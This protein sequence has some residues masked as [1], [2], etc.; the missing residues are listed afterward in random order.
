MNATTSTAPA[1]AGTAAA[2]G[3]AGSSQPALVVQ[4]LVSGYT[5]EVDI[6]RGVGLEV[7]RGEI[8][9]VLGPNGAGKSTLIKTIAGLVPVRSGQVML[10]GQ[11]LVGIAAHRMVSRGLA[12]VP[13]TN[14]IFSRMSIEEN[15][16]MGACARHD[17]AGID[18]DFARMYELFPRLRE[19][20]RQAAG[21]L[22]GGERQMVAVARALMSRPTML[23]LDEP[24]A[25]LSPKL[26]G[27]VFAKVREVRGLGVTMLIVEQNAKAAL[28]ISD[29]GYI[30]AQGRE[31]VSGNAQELLS[32][33]EV[34]E[35]YLG[36]RRGLS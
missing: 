28:A 6:L 29:R 11:S 4:G 30:L 17:H 7:R 33:P 25:G 3:E 14:N 36:V 26:V 5:P 9:T 20:R 10:D 35:L 23:M 18:E 27:V 24:S 1:R 31:Q 15:L 32:N 34:G 16:Q 2:P 19:R 22:S 8:V 13:Q 12:Y 21:T